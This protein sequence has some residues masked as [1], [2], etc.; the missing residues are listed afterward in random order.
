MFLHAS[1]LCFV[2]FRMGNFTSSTTGGSSTAC[3]QYVQVRTPCGTVVCC[4]SLDNLVLPVCDQFGI[5]FSVFFCFFFSLC[6]SR[7]SCPNV[8]FLLICWVFLVSHHFC[9]LCSV[10]SI[11]CFDVFLYIF[12][13]K[14]CGPRSSTYN[15]ICEQTVSK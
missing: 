9:G 13:L 10:C 14:V 5:H 6:I 7:C 12:N 4:G 11:T 2:F 3:V 8:D 1:M 15:S